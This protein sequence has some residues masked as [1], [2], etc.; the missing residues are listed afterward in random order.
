MRKLLLF[1]VALLFVAL[2]IWA[3]VI[4]GTIYDN[5]D[6]STADLSQ[7]THRD[8][9]LG[10]DV[11]GNNSG[12]G[13][14]WYHQNVGGRRAAGMTATPTAHASSAPNSD[15]VYLWD[16]TQY[17]NYQPYEIW[18][19]TSI[20]FPSPATISTNGKKGEAPF[21]PTTGEWNWFLEFHDDSNAKPNC[22][23]EYANLAFDVKTDDLVQSDVVGTTHVRM[24]VRIMGGDDCAPSIVWVDGPPLQ[25]DHWYEMLLHIKWDP[26]GG[27]FEWY[28]DNFSTPYYSNLNIPTLFTRPAGYVSPSYTSLTL[29]NYRLHAPWNSTIYLGPLAVASTQSSVLSAF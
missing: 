4:T 9:G 16:P 23:Q 3:Q 12:A 13:Y 29:T 18:L 7:W 15:S 14:L 5:R 24:A 28:L 19:R 10:T 17:W 11:G 1:A 27:I 26:S 25:W 2:A 6:M 22:S 21:A 8:Y 20:M